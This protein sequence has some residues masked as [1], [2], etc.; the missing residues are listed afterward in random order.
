MATNSRT[1]KT[2]DDDVDALFRLP[3]AEFVG[4]RKTLA[5]RLKKEGQG[6]ESDRVKALP[7]PSISVWAV[8][9]LYWQHREEFEQVIA[10]GQQ[11]RRA[12]T[13]TR[14]G[15]LGDLNE[16]IAARRDALNHLS[17]LAAALLRNAGHNPGLDTMRRIATTL[18]AV[19]A[20]P[21][22]PDDQAAGRL[23]RDLDPPGFESLVPFIRAV[24]TPRRAEEPARA[25]GSSP[26]KKEGKPVL[27]TASKSRTA[28]AKAPQKSKPPR[29]ASRLKE[30][31]Q[32]K[33]AAAKT[34]LQDARKL[35]VDARGKAQSLETA[36]KK[37]EREAKET[38]KQKREA[39]QRFREASAAST[40]AAL[41]SHNLARER[42][43]AAKVLADAQRA[44]ERASEELESLFREG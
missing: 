36:Q 28:A 17:E 3:L 11:F 1:P 43:R 33:L 38:E 40:E 2:I 20:Y 39:E 24:N 37:A 26:T 22:L 34:S 41:R 25:S 44:V 16:A 19:S 23:T 9:Q 12:Q 14:A 42:D 21:V 15:K 6:Q 4:A 35:L 30:T 31:R 10:A 32:A 13:T 7:K 29:E 27:T 18:E 8:N 5:A